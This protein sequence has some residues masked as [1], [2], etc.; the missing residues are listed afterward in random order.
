MMHLRRA[1]LV[2]APALLAGCSLAADRAEEDAP[3][4]PADAT[5]VETTDL[6]GE[7]L[8]AVIRM[9]TGRSDSVPENLIGT[10]TYSHDECEKEGGPPENRDIRASIGF[11][12]DRTYAMDVEGFPSSGSYRYEGGNY[13]RITLDNWLN[14]AVVGDTLQNWSEGDAVYQCGR[15]FVRAGGSG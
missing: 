13:P 8:A 11:E 1:G 5:D 3:A 9:D 14:F 7:A 6:E 12:A 10:W 4:P 15:V 2:V